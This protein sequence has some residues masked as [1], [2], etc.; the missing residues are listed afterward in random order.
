MAELKT[1]KT[2]ASVTDFLKAI[3]DEARRKD[4]QTVA[5]LMKAATGAAPKMWGAGIVGFGDFH[6][7]YESGRAGDWFIMGFAPRKGDVTLYLWRLDDKAALMKKLGKHSAG[8]G[9][10]HIRRLSDVD[11]NVLAQLIEVAALGP[12]A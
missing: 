9:C 1:K 5:R 3:P 10:L 7:K 12:K 8:K 6:Y 11:V 4:C 2:T